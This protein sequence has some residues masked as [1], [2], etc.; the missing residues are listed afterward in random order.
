MLVFLA[1]PMFLDKV[2]EGVSLW[3]SIPQLGSSVVVPVWFAYLQMV[4]E[5]C[6]S[7]FVALFCMSRRS[8]YLPTSALHAM[9]G[10]L[11]FT[12][13]IFLQNSKWNSSGWLLS[14]VSNLFLNLVPHTSL[15]YSNIGFS[16]E[17]KS[18]SQSF[19]GGLY[20]SSDF[21]SM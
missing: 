10:Q 15:P 18:F 4:P 3:V 21:L 1:E 14:H 17:S 7:L 16:I 11:L 5:F 6:C 12:P 8:G 13:S 20:F 19:M 9:L 2:V